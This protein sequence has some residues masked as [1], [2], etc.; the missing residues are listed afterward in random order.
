[1]FYVASDGRRFDLATRQTRAGW[2]CCPA[3]MTS[4][5][6]ATQI[7]QLRVAVCVLGATSGTHWWKSDF[8]SAAAIEVAGFNFP[9]RPEIAGYRAA[10]AAAKRVHDERIGRRGIVHLFRLPVE[11]ESTL[12]RRSGAEHAQ[13]H[14]PDARMAME[15]LRATAGV[16]IDPPEGPVQVGYVADCVTAG[17]LSELAAHYHA[18]FRQQIQV[19]PYFA[20]K[21]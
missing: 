13:W 12:D 2:R 3:D 16:T 8:L 18:A 6:L 21:A 15:I 5:S 7:I 4:E 14:I 9:R 17:G 20:A 10:V 19:F 11:T 1:M